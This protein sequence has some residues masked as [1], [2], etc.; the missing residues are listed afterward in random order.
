MKKTIMMTCL[1]MVMLPFM[2]CDSKPTDFDHRADGWE[3]WREGQIERKKITMEKN[4]S[5]EERIFVLEFVNGEDVKSSR[6]HKW[7]DIKEGSTGHLYSWDG[8]DNDNT[9]MWV[10]TGGVA[11]V[12][13][14]KKKGD[15]VILKTAT[16]NRQETFIKI[17]PGDLTAD[18]NK[19]KFSVKIYNWQNIMIS[20]PAY[21]TVLV[22][23]KN[24]LVTTAYITSTGDWKSEMDRKKLSGGI[25]LKEVSKWKF[26]DLE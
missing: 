18:G 2:G 21:K 22:K 7:E 25:A 19:L 13:S 10:S 9:Y 4:G 17:S 26:V 5:G 15:V 11:P 3:L 6:F 12:A 14:P 8:M 16:D 24:G 20:P 1:I 23:F